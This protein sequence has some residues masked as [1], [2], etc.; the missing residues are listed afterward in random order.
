LKIERDSRN[1]DRES[2]MGVRELQGLAEFEGGGAV[3]GG[4]GGDEGGEKGE[5]SEED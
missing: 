2:G 1:V 5:G 3:G 4:L